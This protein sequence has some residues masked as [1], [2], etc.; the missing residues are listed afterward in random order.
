[1]NKHFWTAIDGRLANVHICLPRKDCA[2]IVL[3]T[4]KIKV[5]TTV[6]N[7]YVWI[8]CRSQQPYIHSRHR[9]FNIRAG[10]LIFTGFSVTYSHSFYDEMWLK[11]MHPVHKYTYTQISSLWCNKNTIIHICVQNIGLFTYIQCIFYTLFT[12][13]TEVVKIHHHIT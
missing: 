10:Y 5:P 8:Q 12:P 4:F 1:M 7:R 2:R 6:W 11:P 13:V 3:I 9:I